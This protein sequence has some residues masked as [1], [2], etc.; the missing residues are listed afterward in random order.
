MY[1]L[2]NLKAQLLYAA[3]L[4]SDNHRF[5]AYNRAANSLG[6]ISNEEFI[7]IDDFTSLDYIGPKINDKILEYKSTGVFRDLKN[8]DFMVKHRVGFDTVRQHIS[9]IEEYV[10]TLK[11][12]L[13]ASVIFVG[14]YRR[15]ADWIADIDAIVPSTDY[16]ECVELCYN[17]YSVLSSGNTKSSFLIDTN[18]NVQLDI[19]IY[20]PENLAFALLH[21]TGSVQSNVMMRSKAKSLGLTLNQYGLFDQDGNKID[22]LNTEKD[23]YDYLGMTYVE[24]ENR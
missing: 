20:E 7:L 17:K 15:K 2:K 18:T 24:P 19:N 1:T 10:S 4:N 5:W 6:Q 12:S 8:T 11:A 21:H 22:N 14:S 3:E 13:P 23:V 16:E 9:V